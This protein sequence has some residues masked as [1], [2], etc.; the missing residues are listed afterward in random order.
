MLHFMQVAPIETGKDVIEAAKNGE[1]D[2]L[3]QQAITMGMEA[4]KSILL[5]VV[6]AVV[7]RYIVKFIN[8]LVAG[9]LERR[10][11]EPTIQTFLKSFVNILLVTLLIITV[12]STL[13]VNT[14]SLA[15]LLASAGL[16]V[17]MALSGNMQ[18]LAGGLILL[19]FK[20]YKVGDFIEAQGVSGIVKAIQI[21][22]TV[23]TTPD[24]KVLF[25]PNG[26]LSSGNVINYSKNGTRR[27]D[28]TVSVEYGTDVEKVKSVTLELLK[29]DE[30]ILQDPAP[31]IAVKELADSSVD[32]TLRVW[33]NVADYWDVFFDTN[34]RIYTE[35]N[36][37]G[38]GFPF[39]QLQIHQ[40]HP[41]TLPL[42]RGE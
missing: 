10:N 17:G 29:K 42:Q 13:G 25:I 8:K 3:I 30:R 18:N 7:G 24:N 28:F 1:I 33:V 14:T 6:V 31:F 37:Q 2:Q 15:A 4:G 27:V 20:P 35:F 5:A 16:A 41:L 19:F 23:L 21:F 38:I 9:M 26:P 36:K 12:I 22:H 40:T 32:F 34:E 39:P 11:V